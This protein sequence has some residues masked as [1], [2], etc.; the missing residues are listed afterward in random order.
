MSFWSRAPTSTFCL[1][2]TLGGYS[3]NTGEWDSLQVSS[4]ETQGY[5]SYSVVW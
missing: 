1:D 5:N 3:A 4:S 2:P